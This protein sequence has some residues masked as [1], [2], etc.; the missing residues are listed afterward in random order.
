MAKEI[1]RG[2]V[3]R[4]GPR[5]DAI[6]LRL[7]FVVRSVA[8]FRSLLKAL[9]L[10]TCLT[11]ISFDARATSLPVAK[12]IEA[13]R[14]QLPSVIEFRK[15]E[16]DKYIAPTE[17]LL[18]NWEKFSARTGLSAEDQVEVDKTTVEILYTLGHAHLE[19]GNLAAAEPFI[20]R[21][22]G[23]AAKLGAAGE[24]EAGFAFTIAGKLR[25]MQGR[26][27]D[28]IP[29]LEKAFAIR[30]NKS[31]AFWDVTV[32]L[33][34]LAQLR[35]IQGDFKAA[36]ELLLALDSSVLRE[37]A[38]SERAAVDLEAGDY[39]SIED[40]VKPALGMLR[41]RD[42]ADPAM[43][44]V[45]A[46]VA[47]YYLA[48]GSPERAEEPAKDL[49]ARR[50][51]MPLPNQIEI[52]D[53]VTRLARV[54]LALGDVDKAA[55]LVERAGKI[56]NETASLIHPGRVSFYELQAELAVRRNDL[57]AA[58][59]M[60]VM[61]HTNAESVY[62]A[63]NYQTARLQ[64]KL[65]AIRLGR[66]D[67]AGAYTAC[68]RASEALEKTL[69]LLH[70]DTSAA[71]DDLARVYLAQ[72]KPDAALTVL[73]KAMDNRDRHVA[74]IFGF[75]SEMQKMRAMALLRSETDLALRVALAMPENEDAVRVG[76]TAVLRR[77][78][79]VLDGMAMSR[80]ALRDANSPDESLLMDQIVSIQK[81]IV[82]L[83]LRGPQ[84]RSPDEHRAR[85]RQL[86]AEKQKLEAQES[87]VSQRR[88]LED[89]PVRVDE[90]AGALPKD[91]ALVEYAVVPAS[92]KNA[93]ARY[94]AWVVF[95]NGT[96][97]FVDIG[98][99][100]HVDS[101]VTDARRKFANPK[102]DPKAVARK[103]DEAI[104]QPVRKV[105]DRT[106]WLFISPDGDLNLVPFGALR[107]ELGHWLL[108]TYSFTYLTSGRD[109]LLGETI[110]EPKEPGLPAVFFGNADFGEKK[111]GRRRF[112]Q[113]DDEAPARGPRAVDLARMKFSPLPG[114]ASE[115]ASIEKT[116]S[117]SQTFLGEKATEA[118]VK[119]VK[120]PRILHLATHGFFLPDKRSTV[121]PESGED[122]VSALRTD[123]PLVR[124]GVALVGANRLRSGEEDG[125]LTAYEAAG[126]DLYGTKLVVLS[127][128]ETGVGEARSGEGV[129]GMRRAL[130]IA[131]AETIV[132]SL[133]QVDDTGTQKLM[134]GYYERLL[135]GG[136]R[137]E[138]L[139]QSALA[140]KLQ[141]RF[142]HPFFW[143]SF[144]ASGDGTALSG[145]QTPP[146]PPPVAPGPRGCACAVPGL[147]AD[148][149][150]LSAA[151]VLAVA[152]AWGMG[153]R[154]RRGR[155]T[156]T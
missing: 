150:Q 122:D 153:A 37:V 100:D 111:L 64:G 72:S 138:S 39:K 23:P 141:P 74:R 118:E 136:G 146:A 42:L 2:R 46:H 7:G 110:D 133:W 106:Q 55:P 61:A 113:R 41:D 116:V 102:E 17:K 9:V 19:M 96:V 40:L 95:Q 20:L 50:E 85:I 151:W 75:V 63:E 104:M 5:V 145:K 123:N 143:A 117:G 70:P 155:E 57:P 76:L 149:G 108:D 18:K 134:A 115:I 142:E 10:A 56:L 47:D 78:G 66:Q 34:E 90:V 60:M 80:A 67:L 147:S 21:A 89:N 48:L 71:L 32:L 128:C 13:T 86:D 26:Y 112:S 29:F 27:A 105:L 43:I 98:P 93:V 35:K 103:L 54:Y 139:R 73:R 148:E 126:L 65:G 88:L 101:L 109:L 81:E 97:R 14:T 38:S 107:D 25:R 6:A 36:R 130:A 125:V 1:R 44:R 92:E 30:K 135:A 156:T 58:E 33:S 87:R 84:G 51:K 15:R 124:A 154:R 127:A 68:S 8:M 28:A 53:A 24:L 45:L 91:A 79:R 129:Y 83:I 4:Q 131:G 52:A 69:G 114:T 99:V 3:A 49:L 62:G 132:M 144:I 12:E 119:A 152:A 137:A 82:Q 22:L 11:A 120:H 121:Q 77:K 31:V 16:V 59:K 94:I 140:L